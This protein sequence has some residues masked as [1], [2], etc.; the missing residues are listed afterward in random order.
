[1]S[2]MLITGANG[3]IGQA[4]QKRLVADGHEVV[5]VPRELL[6]NFYKL[7]TFINSH[8]P[9][10]IFHLGAY[11]NHYNQKDYRR[12]LID[13]ICATINLLESIKFNTKIAFF[14]FSSSS[15]TLDK[16][17][18][19]S[20]S[21]QSTELIAQQ[22]KNTYQMTIVNVR[23]YSVFGPGE[24]DHRF[25]PQ[26]IQHLFSGETMQVDLDAK[27]DWIFIDD[28]IDAL[29]KG[30]TN[31]GTGESYSNK[32][33]VALLENISDLRLTLQMQRMRSYDTNN[34]VSPNPV[35]HRSLKDALYETYDYYA[36]KYQ[37]SGSEATDSGHLG[38][39]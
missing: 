10:S 31:I 2:K 30:Q 19:Y 1:M 17:T 22:Y 5:A 9:D 11:G 23:P 34:W 15:V 39:A 29:L 16:Q 25:I 6:Y 27:H 32:E 13:N 38:Q 7:R 12:V 33:I 4:L 26:I 28:F 24:A 21:K 35:P 37:K 36:T 20:V 8:K 3:F 18:F 14:N